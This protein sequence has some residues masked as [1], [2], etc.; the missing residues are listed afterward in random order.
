MVSNCRPIFVDTWCN[1][2]FRI[3]ACSS[4]ASIANVQHVIKQYYSLM[5]E[6]MPCA[7]CSH[8]LVSIVDCVCLHVCM[9]AC[10]PLCLPVCLSVCQSVC[11][12]VCLPVCLSVSD[13]VCLFVCVLFT[14]YVVFPDYENCA[15]PISTNPGSIETGDHWI[16]CVACFV[17][18][19]QGFRGRWA[20]V[21]LVVCCGCV[22][23]SCLFVVFPSNG[24][25][26]LQ[27]WGRL[28]LFTSLLLRFYTCFNRQGKIT[29]RDV[30][31]TY[32]VYAKD[33]VAQALK[34]RIA[35][36]ACN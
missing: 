4:V 14:V 36:V 21:E 19:P 31:S 5:L 7:I 11:L 32:C 23:V 26:L 33:T 3:L 22:G 29:I 1:T 12:S 2:S 18:R 9:S 35:H 8:A 34:I 28:A 27:V 15:R 20:A 6:S 16:T 13:S 25:G 17:A 30:L 24:H 10:L